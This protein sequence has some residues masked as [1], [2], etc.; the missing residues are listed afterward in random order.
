MNRYVVSE[1][2]LGGDAYV[3]EM[4]DEGMAVLVRYERQYPDHFSYETRGVCYDE[5]DRVV[6]WK[7]AF[8][9]ADP[10]GDQT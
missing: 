7:H 3:E 1:E 6:P 2:C 10:E 8:V 5:N 4:L 9:M